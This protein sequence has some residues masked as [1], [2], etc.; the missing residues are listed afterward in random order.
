[1]QRAGVGKGIV[2]TAPRRLGDPLEDLP[3]RADPVAAA[4][5][6]RRRAAGFAAA[7]GFG[8]ERPSRGGVGSLPGAIGPVAP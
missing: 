2:D 3:A 4:A 7:F 8:R 5:D 1:M 6:G